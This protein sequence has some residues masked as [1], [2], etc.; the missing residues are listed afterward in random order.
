MQSA[1]ETKEPKS[2]DSEEDSGD[3]EKSRAGPSWEMEQQSERK[4]YVQGYT[5][6]SNLN[7]CVSLLGRRR[8]SLTIKK[9]RSAK[10]TCWPNVRQ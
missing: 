7:L 3:D 4:E 1:A 8:Q 10:K 5:Y 2:G 6:S 9:K